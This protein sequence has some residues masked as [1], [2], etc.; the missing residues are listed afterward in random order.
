MRTIGCKD[1]TERSANCHSDCN[2]YKIYCQKNEES[3][4]EHRNYIRVLVYEIDQKHKAM[5][6]KRSRHSYNKIK[7]ER[8]NNAWRSK[9]SE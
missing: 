1:C 8:G 4:K 5:K 6:D 7:H 9:Q 2:E 3:K